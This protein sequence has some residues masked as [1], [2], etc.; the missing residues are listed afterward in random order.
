MAR[1]LPQSLG[2]FLAKSSALL[3]LYAMSQFAAADPIFFSPDC[4]D[5]TFSAPK[6]VAA[7]ALARETSL[8]SRGPTETKINSYRLTVSPAFQPGPAL[9]VRLDVGAAAEPRLFIFDILKKEKAVASTARVTH[10]QA[11]DFEK[12]YFTTDFSP[13]AYPRVVYENGKKMVIIGIRDGHTWVF[14]AL[15]DGKYRCVHRSAHEDGTF[16]DLVRS[17]LAF[18]RRDTDAYR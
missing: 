9:I 18:A 8:Y 3:C 10:D 4:P 12:A 17:L 6:V 2:V 11:S 15:V 13:V 14:E 1:P 16:R 5:P 7:M